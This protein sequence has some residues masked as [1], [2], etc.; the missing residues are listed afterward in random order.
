MSNERP[1]AKDDASV[2]EARPMRDRPL[3]PNV[4]ELAGEHRGEK[5]KGVPLDPAHNY[6]QRAFAASEHVLDE[7]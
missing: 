5:P 3:M 1:A 4:G 7:D 2:Y 6:W